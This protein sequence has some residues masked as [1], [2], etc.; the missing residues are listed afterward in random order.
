MLQVEETELESTKTTKKPFSS[1]KVTRGTAFSLLIYIAVGIALA[2]P[3]AQDL[4]NVVTGGAWKLRPN[5]ILLGIL[6]FVSMSHL[7]VVFHELGHWGFGFINGFKPSGLILFPF[8]WSKGQHGWF[9]RRISGASFGGG[10]AIM[11]PFGYSKLRERL[12]WFI[13]GAGLTNILTG[14]LSLIYGTFLASFNQGKP[15]S[16]GHPAFYLVMFGFVSIWTGIRALIP[17]MYRIRGFNRLMS[18]GMRI[19]RLIENKEINTELTLLKIESLIF[20]GNR[21][22]SWSDNLMKNL[23]PVSI[24]NF[25]DAEAYFL[26]YLHALDQ[27]DII[28]ATQCLEKALEYSHLASEYSQ[29]SLWFEAAFF[30]ARYKQDAVIARKWFEQ[31][32]DKPALHEG[33]R[34]RAEAALHWIENR[35][36]RAAFVAN[37]ALANLETRSDTGLILAEREW[38]EAIAA[39]VAHAQNE[40]LEPFDLVKKQPRQTFFPVQGIWVFLIW[41]GLGSIG[42]LPPF[43]IWWIN[44]TQSQF[45]QKIGNTLDPGIGGIIAILLAFPLAVVVTRVGYLIAGHKAGFGF[46][47]FQVSGFVKIRIHNG[48]LKFDTS[49]ISNVLGSTGSLVAREGQYLILSLQKTMWGGWW[50]LLVV[51]LVGMALS[52]LDG[53]YNWGQMTLIWATRGAIVDVQAPFLPSLIGLIYFWLLLTPIGLLLIAV[54]WLVSFFGIHV[55]D[56]A[57]RLTLLRKGGQ[58]AQREVARVAIL[59]AATSGVRPRDW[60]NSWIELVAQGEPL[61][62][63]DVHMLIC[64]YFAALDHNKIDQARDYLERASREANLLPFPY[65][66]ALV[67][68]QVFYTAWFVGDASTARSLLKNEV[69]YRMDPVSHQRVLASV[70]FVEKNFAKAKQAIQAARNAILRSQHPGI[71]IVEMDLVTQIECN[72]LEQESNINEP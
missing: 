69:G 55:F 48:R 33:S 23:P 52:W 28:R 71:A 49:A 14:I 68:E 21:P 19:K 36:A 13:A 25:I 70:Y 34:L 8:F 5:S 17:Q 47:A 30:H 63:R 45:M 6:T 20:Q 41:L 58:E 35:P 67:L 59:G 37:V 53:H 16:W 43:F 9:V 57:W 38:L 10:M 60:S 40:A 65:N 42:V 26:S 64:A 54:G 1:I 44:F 61:N 15:S 32:F 62:P 27:N 7:A 50:A 2:L 24:E 72:I 29:S 4:L 56:G 46:G 66:R 39:D 12:I 11:Y 18:D 3:A 51:G 31:A 22:K